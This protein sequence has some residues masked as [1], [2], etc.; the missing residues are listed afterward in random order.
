VRDASPRVLTFTTLFPNRQRPTHGIF[1]RERILALAKLVHLR[2]VAPVPWFPRTRIFGER[3]YRYS[4][5]PPTEDHEGTRVDHPR[6]PAIPKLCKA[7]DGLLLAAGSFAH[8]LRVRNEFPFDIVDA[9]WAYPD[10]AAAAILASRLRVPLAVTV[11]GDDINVFL[12]EFSRRP[13]IRWA[14]R[15]ADLVIALSTELKGI[16]AAA[17]IAESKISVIPNGINPENFHLVDRQLA[18]SRLGL[19]SEG[20]F[21]LSVGRLHRSKGFPVL[22]EAAGHLAKRFPDLHV[23]I[24][25]P[26]DHEAD[27][28]PQILEVA[29]RCGLVDRLHLVGA[30]DP[31]LLKYWYGASNVFCLPTA[32]EGSANALLEALACGLPCVTTPVGGNADAV[33]TRDVGYLVEPGARPMSEALAAAI[34]RSWDARRISQHGLRRTWQTVA[35]ECRTRLAAAVDA[36]QAASSREQLF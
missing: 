4:Q 2:V 6:F 30:Q 11:R 20:R 3:Y 22:I 14:L 23:Y 15:K 24:V 8:L 7:A 29:A 17:G 13:W 9:H 33:S 35:A 28:R 27:A 5:V 19:P 34:T 10:G 25:G 18:R 1:V 36:R 21:I 16:V 31:E 26:P 32:R 12:G